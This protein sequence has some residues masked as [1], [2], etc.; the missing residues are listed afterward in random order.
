M[1]IPHHYCALIITS[2][3][4]HCVRKG[5]EKGPGHITTVKEAAVVVA[6]KAA[7]DGQVYSADPMG[8]DP[9][10]LFLST[11]DRAPYGNHQAMTKRR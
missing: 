6:K 1:F 3:A 9:R 4:A 7:L 5:K 2:M 8:L 10:F 11:L